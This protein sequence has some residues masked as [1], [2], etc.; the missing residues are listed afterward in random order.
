MQ[1]FVCLLRRRLVPPL[2]LDLEDTIGNVTIVK[3]THQ[4]SEAR[5]CGQSSFIEKKLLTPRLASVNWK[6]HTVSFMTSWISKIK[7]QSSSF[8]NY[9][10]IGYQ[11]SL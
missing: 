1:S 7:I 3:L 11:Q 6:E 9:F 8:P 2:S 4:I 5:K 10:A